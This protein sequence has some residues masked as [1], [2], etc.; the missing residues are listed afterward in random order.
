[1]L[2][3]SGAAPIVIN[4]DPETVLFFLIPELGVAPPQ[5]MLPVIGSIDFGNFL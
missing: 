2:L 3:K 4:T 5:I 1:M